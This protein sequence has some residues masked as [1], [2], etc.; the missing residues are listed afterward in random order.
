[1]WE[2]AN[3][4]GRRQDPCDRLH[5]CFG[6]EL[7]ATHAGV[8]IVRSNHLYGA[9]ICSR[10]HRPSNR[11]IHG[12]HCT[13][14]YNR[15]REVEIGRNGKGTRP[16]KHAHLHACRLLVA[17]NGQPQ[18]KRFER[19][20]DTAEA[21]VSVLRHAQGVVVFGFKGII[22]SSPRPVQLELF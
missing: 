7:G 2:Q 17:I 16:V 13:S 6:C 18:A 12:E 3:A 10:C 11:L 19:I 8:E 22:Q 14:C 1:M 20:A 21:I 4:K 9:R 5:H 15:Q